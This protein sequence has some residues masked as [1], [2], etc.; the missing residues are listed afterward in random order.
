IYQVC[1]TLYTM[2]F[3]ESSP[4]CYDEYCFEL[5]SYAFGFDSGFPVFLA[6]DPDGLSDRTQIQSFN[7][8][9][10][11]A[12]EIIRLELPEMP[13]RTQVRIFDMQG[14]MVEEASLLN[15]SGTDPNMSI[16]AL[17]AGPYL[18]IANSGDKY[19]RSTFVKAR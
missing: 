12:R 11:P 17:P 10:N 2:Q 18:I 4:L 8:Y 9:P 14:Q 5:D 1:I 16:S 15:Q 6:E 3:F 19:F 7:I 13:E